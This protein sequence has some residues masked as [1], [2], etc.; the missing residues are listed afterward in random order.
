MSPSN[1]TVPA[2]LN[3][4]APYGLGPCVLW[5][6]F[7]DQ[8][9]DHLT[10]PGGAKLDY[11]LTDAFW[12]M[13]WSVLNVNE[14]GNGHIPAQNGMMVIAA[15]QNVPAGTYSQTRIIKIGPAGTTLSQTSMTISVIVAS[16]CTLPAPSTSRLDFSA[17]IVDGRISQ[18]YRQSTSMSGAS[19]SGPSM[20][21]LRG[22][23]MAGNG[24]SGAGYRNSIDY[25]ATAR[26]GTASAT[27]LTSAAAQASVAL[28][29]SSGVLDLDVSL[30]DGGS[31]L[32]A[33]TY[34]G[35]VTV[36]LEPSN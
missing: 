23:P 4:S 10:G 21:T 3:F 9:N 16:A 27:L 12:S 34:S 31:P 33:G 36:V 6:T 15:G 30:V 7:A 26:F 13:D 22:A 20:L 11:S 24:P 14:D 8:R 32:A 2:T 28:P 35:T 18:G 1:A 19:C 25:Q 17:G 5:I 29:A